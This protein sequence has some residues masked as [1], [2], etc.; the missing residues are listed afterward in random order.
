MFSV[1]AHRGASASARENTVEAFALAVEAGADGVELDVRLS[2][3]GALVVHHDPVIPDVGPIH[4]LRVPE[5]PAWVPLLDAAVEAC[6]DV[7]VNIEI[8]NLPTEPSFDPEERLAAAVARFVVDR[9]LTARVIVSCFHLPTIDAVRSADASIPTGYLTEP[10]WDQYLALDQVRRRGHDA[11]HPQQ[12]AVNAALCEAAH[13]QG[14]A[15]NTWTVDDPD[16]MEW[17][18]DCGVDVI[19]TNVPD[20]GVRIRAAKEG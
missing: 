17:L 9:G 4:D 15:V 19:M 10:V 1:F 2:A 20:M 14:T 11:L 18:A 8:K 3:D 6:G 13:A 12:L 16:R 5:L 7:V